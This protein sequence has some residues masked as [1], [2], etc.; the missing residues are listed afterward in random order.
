MRM[1]RV[2]PGHPGRE[3][4]AV[5]MPGCLGLVCSLVLQMR[6]LYYPALLPHWGPLPCGP[7][8]WAS[9][10]RI[11]SGFSYLKTISPPSILHLLSA[12]SRLHPFSEPVIKHS[13]LLWPRSW[14]LHFFPRMIHIHSLWPME[15]LPTGHLSLRQGLLPSITPF[16][17]D[18]LGCPRPAIPPLSSHPSTDKPNTASLHFLFSTV[19]VTLQV[20]VTLWTSK[21]V[22]HLSFLLTAL[23]TWNSSH[24]HVHPS[25]SF[26]LLPNPSGIASLP[27]TA[28]PLTPSNTYCLRCSFDIS[29]WE[30]S[31]NST[32]SKRV[33]FLH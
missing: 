6:T 28:P 24:P 32:A 33:Y 11:S 18:T 12:S 14:H 2:L 25:R 4:S 20:V 13:C 21:Y 16:F 7:G 19:R 17:Q 31:Q 22:F 3:E 1:K 9:F 5:E 30:S 10:L 23:L 29:A 27:G 26:S 15:L 8:S